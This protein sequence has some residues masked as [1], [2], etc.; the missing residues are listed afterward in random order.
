MTQKAREW[1][2][3]RK[4]AV[5]PNKQPNCVVVYKVS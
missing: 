3:D 4:G 5:R 1:E 2:K